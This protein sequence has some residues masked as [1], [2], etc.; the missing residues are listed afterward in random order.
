MLELESS[1]HG[2]ALIYLYVL[3]PL[4]V[5][6]PLAILSSSKGA[7]IGLFWAKSWSD[8]HDR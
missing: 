2:N 6:V 1:G 7:L 3:V 8:Q 5:I 4:S